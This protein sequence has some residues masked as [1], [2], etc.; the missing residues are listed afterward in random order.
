[1]YTYPTSLMKS[2]FKSYLGLQRA[3]YHGFA[4]SL[5]ESIFIGIYYYLTI[6]FV[7]VL[8]YDMATSGLIISCYGIGAVLGGMLGGKLA[9]EAPPIIV[10]ASSLLLQSIAYFAFNK[11]DSIFLLMCNVFMLGVASYGFITANHIWILN[12]CKEYEH[13]RLKAINILATTSNLGLGLSAM[14][15]S[16]ILY[17]GFPVIFLISG[18]ILFILACVLFLYYKNELTKTQISTAH[19]KEKLAEKNEFFPHQP[20]KKITILILL[21]V[22]FVGLII[23]QIS[24][25]YVIYIKESYPNIGIKAFSFLFALNTFMV[26]FLGIQLGDYIKKYNKIL[27]VGVGGF[28]IGFGMFMLIFAYTFFMAIAACIV[29]SVGEII[30]FSMAQLV[31]YQNG[32]Q[33]KKGYSLGLYRMIFASSRVLGPAIGGVIYTMLG[34]SIVWIISGIIGLLCLV[35]CNYYKEYG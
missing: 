25:T 26:A 9:D 30:F 13:Q 7:D 14:M 11:L 5:T 8:H 23:T 2:Y 29:Y 35:S 24:S 1:M 17:F 22:F 3:C 4:L 32:P 19:Q 18:C 6:Y 20:R 12:L 16:K 28:L 21:N 34:G 31:C 15:M 27:M 10:V 33:S